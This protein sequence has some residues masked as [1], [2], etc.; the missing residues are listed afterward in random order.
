MNYIF[1]C[2]NYSISIFLSLNHIYL[3]TIHYTLYNNDRINTTTN[4]NTSIIISSNNLNSTTT[5]H[6]S[7]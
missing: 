6:Y 5:T 1:T 4:S 7:T 3:Y 2:I